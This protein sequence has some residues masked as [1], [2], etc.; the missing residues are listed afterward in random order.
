[1]KFKDKIVFVAGGT[2]ELG[3]SVVRRFLSEGARVVTSYFSEPEKEAFKL[4]IQKQYPEVE[5]FRANL[6]KES[7][8]EEAFNFIKEH[9]HQLDILCNLV[10]GYMEKTPLISLTERDWD[11]ML[12][13]NLKSCFFC[14]KHGLRLMQERKEGRIINVSAMVGLAP[15]EG[16]G[17]YG[18]S[19]GAVALLTK[20]A[21]AEVK[22]D[23][24]SRITVN[25]IA[26]SILTT[27]S[28]QG[29]ASEEEM[30]SWVTLEQA[31]DT[32]AYLASEEASAINGQIIGVYGRK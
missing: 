13:L 10:G 20:I 14:T 1:L 16:R 28:N 21:A 26:P 30:A 22:S 32:I 6:L 24:K 31:T 2:G 19:K 9:F 4:T 8:V 27:S 12:N 29:W 17:A 25:A 11:F 3:Q 5:F 7:E 18:I 23:S 15:E